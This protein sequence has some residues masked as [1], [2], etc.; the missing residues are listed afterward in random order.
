MK[1]LDLLKKVAG[2]GLTIAGFADPRLAMLTKAIT[3]AIATAET[4]PGR[5]G[6]EKAL[7]AQGIVAKAAPDAIAA[8]EQ[9]FG[10][11]IVD[12]KLFAEALQDYQEGTVKLYKA[13]G[14]L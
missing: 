7:I 8:Y 5:K 14:L 12:E 13:F 2:A 6:A 4:A 1:A 9:L 11:E 3:E 10:K